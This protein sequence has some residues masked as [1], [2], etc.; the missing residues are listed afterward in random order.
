MAVLYQVW[1]RERLHRVV[2]VL[3]SQLALRNGVKVPWISGRWMNSLGFPRMDSR[4]CIITTSIKLLMFEVD[5]TVLPN[6]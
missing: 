3:K 5:M 4:I 6:I 1:L 2:F